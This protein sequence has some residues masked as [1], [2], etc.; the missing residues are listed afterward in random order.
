[1]TAPSAAER[2]AGGE[3]IGSMPEVVLEARGLSREFGG[4]RAVDGVDLAIREGTIHGLIGPNGAGKTTCFNLL[5]KFLEPTEGSIRFQDRDITGL[6][7]ADVARLGLV[8]SFQ[9]SAVFSHLSVLDNV[10]IALARRGPSYAFWR[11][12]AVLRARDERAHELLADVGLGGDE[13]TVAATLPYGRKRALELATTLALD[14][15][16]LL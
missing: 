14:P 2:L 7:A 11:S 6:R 1:M 15:A 5:S 12:E 8:R 9:I 4:F 13:V 3:A 16:M 10:R